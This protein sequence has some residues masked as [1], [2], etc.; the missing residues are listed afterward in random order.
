M[1][2]LD[3]L[4]GIWVIQSDAIKLPLVF[5]FCGSHS[6]QCFTMSY[7]T[8]SVIGIPG[9]FYAQVDGANFGVKGEYSLQR[10]GLHL[11]IQHVEGDAPSFTSSD[12]RATA[13]EMGLEDFQTSSD[14][15]ESLLD[16]LVRAGSQVG[17]WRPGVT[18]LFTVDHASSNQVAVCLEK[19][20]FS[21]KSS[22]IVVT[23]SESISGSF[24]QLVSSFPG[25]IRH[26]GLK[27]TGEPPKLLF[28]PGDDSGD[29]GGIRRNS[30]RRS[31]ASNLILPLPKYWEMAWHGD[32]PYLPR[33]LAEHLRRQKGRSSKRQSRKSSSRLKEG[34]VSIERL[35]DMREGDIGRVTLPDGRIVEYTV[36]PGNEKYFVV[37]F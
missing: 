3:Y 12:G 31:S 6:R 37:L 18:L 1:G 2:S 16:E 22:E 20:T 7:F 24:N 35:A 15:E 32:R 27:R 21:D 9:K 4:F 17:F 34:K 5:R 14:Y 23:D 33:P 13:A 8:T 11:T 10:D 25:G 36:P 28:L 29:Q 30:A 26:G 19:V